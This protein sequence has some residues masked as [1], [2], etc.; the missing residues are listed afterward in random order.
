LF[1]PHDDRS[2]RPT[3]DVG[4]ALV[5][6]RAGGDRAA[7]AAARVARDGC[8]RRLL[9]GRQREIDPNQAV[10]VAVLARR[11]RSRQELEPDVAERAAPLVDRERRFALPRIGDD[12]R[13]DLGETGDRIL[14]DVG[15]PGAA[16]PRALG[17]VHLTVEVELEEVAGVLR[18]QVVD[19]GSVFLLVRP[20]ARGEHVRV[21]LERQLAEAPAAERLRLHHQIDIEILE[22]LH[23]GRVERVAT[24]RGADRAERRL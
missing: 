19:E 22:P 8:R 2:A 3:R 20:G 24:G 17:D 12:P 15:A 10:D 4:I 14:A 11:A 16:G 1:L 13:S 21:P 5:T 23:E 6:A 7:L 9:G 18:R